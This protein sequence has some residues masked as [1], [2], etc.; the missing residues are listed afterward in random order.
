[1]GIEPYLLSSALNGV[2]AQRLARTICPSCV[3]TYLP[4][5]NVLRDA[6]LS[7]ASGRTFRKGVGCDECHNSGFRGRAGIYAV[8]EVTPAL[9]RLIH[10]AAPTH[11]LHEELQ[12][13]GVLT[14]REEG[15]LLAV[16]HKT[17]LEEVLAVTHSQDTSEVLCDSKR[18][19]VPTPL[20]PGPAL[21]EPNDNV[22]ATEAR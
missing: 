5:V 16:D 11:E 14:L 22:E 9:R 19:R 20:E 8:M 17:S 1:M 7:D 15:V 4:P 18:D 3:T 10:K 2:V 21:Q 12:K 6:G 13:Q